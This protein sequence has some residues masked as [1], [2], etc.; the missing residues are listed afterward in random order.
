MY[1]TSLDGS[2]VLIV[3]GY[4][5]QELLLRANKKT[6]NQV[7]TPPSFFFDAKN[8]QVQPHR[9]RREEF[10]SAEGL[11]PNEMACD[12]FATVTMD[13]LVHQSLTNAKGEFVIESTKRE[14]RIITTDTDRDVLDQELQLGRYVRPEEFPDEYITIRENFFKDLLN[15]PLTIVSQ[16]FEPITLCYIDDYEYSIAEG[17]EEAAYSVTFREYASI[18]YNRSKKS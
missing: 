11:L 9:P 8:I 10:E 18:D 16:L 13:I 17:E 15:R 14:V 6:K 5:P 2:K 4:T 12:N 7:G 1:S 3:S